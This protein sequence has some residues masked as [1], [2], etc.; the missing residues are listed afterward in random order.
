MKRTFRFVFLFV[1]LALSIGA[2]AQKGFIDIKRL[3]D[4]EFY[5]SSIYNLGFVGDSDKYFYTRTGM[6]LVIG[7]K[8]G[9]KEVLNLKEG[10]LKNTLGS[11]FSIRFVS[12]KEF[13]YL[14]KDGIYYYD[15]DNRTV[16]KVCAIP[17]GAEHL[18]VDYEHAAAA[19]TIDGNVWYSKGD[20]APVQLTRDGGNGITYGVAVHRN[21]FGIDRGFFFSDDATK[22]AYYR[23]DESMV[24]QY[25]LVN[26]EAR[27][28]EAA[29]IYYPM[30][31]MTSHQVKVMVYD[32]VSGTTTELQTRE[33]ESVE[34]K[35]AYLTNITWNPESTLIYIQKLNR[36]QNHMKMNAYD[37]R[38]GRLVKT[39]F[40]EKAEKYVEPESPIYFLPEQSDKFIYLSER[41]GF[42][43]AYLYS[44]DGQL[45]RQL[46][47]GEWMITSIEGFDAKGDEFYFFATK[48][49]PLESNMYSCRMKDGKIRRCT[50]AKGTHYNV[51]FN[52]KGTLFLD[53]YTSME[54]ARRVVLLDGKARE[55]KQLHRAEDPWQKL[56]KPQID[57]FTIKAKD[58]TDLYAR[59]IRPVGFDSTRKYPV[60]VYVYGGPHAQLVTDTWLAGANNFFLFLAQQGY[61]VWTVDGRGSANRGYEFESAIWRNCGSIEVSDQMDG[62]NYLKS[63]PYVD[64]ERIG[65]D[66]WSY[67]GFMTISLKLKNPGVFKTATAGGP[68]IDWKWYEIMYGERYM[69][70]PE[71]NPEGYEKSSLLNYVDNLEGKLL[72]IHGAQDN[73][74]VMQ[75]SLE[76]IKSC[77]KK[78][79]QVD[80]FIY[81]DHE[82]NV[83][84]KDRIHLYEKIYEYHKANL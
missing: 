53:A 72:I 2:F 63:L 54:E 67:G 51:A 13:A 9:E 81:P 22:L 39:L 30:A 6:E 83:I 25:P 19:Y 73:T 74:V 84:G 36:K 65:V 70:S 7:D 38:S 46:T 32:A 58:G 4:R 42:N 59:M 62:V 71:D 29:P 14:S 60:L 11:F 26:T 47:S 35:E 82:H 75:H 69:S 43:H 61:I 66:G 24:R 5:P 40:E 52:K 55:V 18:E 76:F 21:E 50:P 57:V 3:Q 16:R 17:E 12:D 34:E 56:D 41:D 44:V 28:A 8:K 48:D 77:I 31:G 15:M 27:E 1:A 80:Y 49:S 64:S 23:M 68:V 33:N 37:V 79:K 20:M 45:I 10:E 78:G